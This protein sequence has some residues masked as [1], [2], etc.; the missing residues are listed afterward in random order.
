MEHSEVIESRVP[1]VSSE[2]LLDEPLSRVN[3]VSS[4]PPLEEV[5]YDGS[6]CDQEVSG[7]VAVRGCRK[8]GVS[9]PEFIDLIEI[10]NKPLLAS[11]F[12]TKSS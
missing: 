2:P 4:E 5:P 1:T 9:L 10:K 8:C 12:V 7:K 6:G 11:N 3:E